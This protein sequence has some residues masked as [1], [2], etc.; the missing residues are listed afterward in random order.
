MTTMRNDLINKIPPPPDVEPPMF[1]GLQSREIDKL[2]E[3]KAEADIALRNAPKS[4]KNPFFNSEYA[5]LDVI[6]R[7]VRPIYGE[8]GLA[9]TQAPWQSADGEML[10]TTLIHKSGQWMRSAMK[11][12]AVPNNKGEVT[13]QSV[14]SAITYAKRYSLAAM[15]N[16]AQTGEDDDG[17]LASDSIDEADPVT[18]T[19]PTA[20]AAAAP[21]S[22]STGEVVAALVPNPSPAAA[23]PRDLMEIDI[24]ETLAAV[25][26]N[27]ELEEWRRK[28]G[29]EMSSL[30]EF[31][32]PLFEELRTLG[33]QKEA[34][35]G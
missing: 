14:G 7:I 1:E 24:Y 11:I 29:P 32:P 30:K 27:A 6:T 18:S 17:N 5:D 31:D 12:K 34:T 4:Q 8:H 13:P 25:S 35:Y 16:I 28:W 15:A 33:K 9:F 2:A 26:S 22:S 20:V 23:S 10:I 3:A 21:V 19:A